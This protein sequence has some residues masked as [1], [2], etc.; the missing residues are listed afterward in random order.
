MR[1]GS[2]PLHVTLLRVEYG[3]GLRYTVPRLDNQTDLASDG[4]ALDIGSQLFKGVERLEVVLFQVSHHF[5]LCCA[6]LFNSC[7]V[8]KR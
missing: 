8:T 7:I 1:L 5:R 3:A 6:V 2:D 4:F